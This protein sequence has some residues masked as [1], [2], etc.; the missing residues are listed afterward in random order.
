[1][2]NGLKGRTMSKYVVGGVTERGVVYPPGGASGLISEMRRVADARDKSVAQV[3]RPH[4]GY[5][6]AWG[7]SWTTD[8]PSALWPDEALG[9]HGQLK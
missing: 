6:W 9:W 3:R 7:Y 1:M 8:S 4:T 2:P 5:F